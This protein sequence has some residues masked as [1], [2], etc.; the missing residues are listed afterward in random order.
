MSDW[1]LEE[2]IK[3]A[4]ER[5]FKDHT[6]DMVLIVYAEVERLRSDIARRKEESGEDLTL[7][8]LDAELL[9]NGIDMRKSHELLINT[10]D[11]KI[12]IESLTK[13]RDEL[14]KDFG[15]LKWLE[16]IIINSMGDATTQKFEEKIKKLE[17]D[18][19]LQEQD[20]ERIIQ[21]SKGAV[22]RMK[23][24]NAEFKE[25]NESV[26]HDWAHCAEGW[27]KCELDLKCLEESTVDKKAWDQLKDKLAAS[28]KA[29]KAA[30][31]KADLMSTVLTESQSELLASEM[32]K[33]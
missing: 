30:E 31:E 21:S 29:R 1:T 27:S 24:E 15:T 26:E 4:K 13:E 3:R 10:L 11:L 8:Q 17:A 9:A 18:L 16:G 20:N 14:K 7:E 6:S 2:V 28:E 12:Q 23:A 22:D 33:R 19:K 5:P 25:Q 32:R